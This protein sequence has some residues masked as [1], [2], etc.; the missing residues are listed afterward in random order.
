[1]LYV[2]IKH[3]NIYVP[4]FFITL[5]L[6]VSFSIFLKRLNYDQQRKKVQFS[7]TEQGVFDLQEV[8]GKDIN[9]VLAVLKDQVGVSSIIIPEFTIADYQKRSKLTV[10]SGAHIIN[11]LR[12]GQLYRTVLSQLR[13]KT[14]INPKATYI[15]IDELKVYNRVL[16]YLKLMFPLE[17]VVEYSGR[18]IQVNVA[19]DKVLSIP[20]GFDEKLLRVYDSY[21][22]N[23]IPELQYS[24]K[25]TKT[26]LDYTFS[27]LEK[28]EK[29]Y[30]IRFSKGFNFGN[31][32]QRE[33]IISLIQQ[34][35]YR[36]VYPEFS[37]N[38]HLDYVAGKV[39]DHVVRVHEYNY[40]N[41][42]ASFSSV[43]S[44]YMRALTERSPNLLV[45]NP[46][47]PK[48]GED[49][50][51][52]NVMFMTKIVRS[53]INNGGEVVDYF[54]LPLKISITLME[55]VCI[56][57]GIFSALFLLLHK[58]HRLR[59][60]FHNM[61]LVLGLAVL[62][63]II[64]G[65]KSITIPVLGLMAAVIGP[66]FAM[67]WGFPETGSFLMD[68]K[69]NKY[70]R[71]VGY[72]SF[73]VFVCFCSALFCVALYSDSVY[74]QQVFSFKGVKLALILPILLVGAYFYC[75]S[76]RVNSIYYVFRRLLHS[77][78]TV[79]MLLFVLGFSGVLAIYI[80]RSGNYLTTTGFEQVLREFL[81]NTLF[82]RPR[83]KEILVGYPAL[84]L[85]FWLLDQQ[86]TRRKVWLF[87]IFSTIA[88]ISFVNSFC[89][90]HT[91]VLIS[92]YRGILGI[93]LGVV[94]AVLYYYIY[95]GIVRL[96]KSLSSIA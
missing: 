60:G 26:T 12:V 28:N 39:S 61:A 70:V 68:H 72:L 80:L 77:Y 87:N 57:L 5:A 21:G 83:F 43:Y 11:T 88:L 71:L 17:S 66:V 3:L 67:I 52:K 41:S 18:I 6:F 15:V 82:V 4:F 59:G 10:L 53:F 29:V 58:V 55:K 50:Y 75:G 16:S 1:M 8:S 85:G 64:F 48:D 76:S 31:N 78:L 74:L 25:V 13:R 84:L 79:V 91:P 47:F 69:F 30:S 51:E 45:L 93:L 86:F 46:I 20:L 38:R 2:K 73:V 44:R 95:L 42:V 62:F 9:Y 33:Y 56:G 40:T 81:E 27:E 96:I 37:K 36:L 32:E 7:V 23:I 92:L 65:I 94:C 49:L 90:F 14:S 24:P 19:I 34:S 63:F 89:H 35:D 54:I 22:L